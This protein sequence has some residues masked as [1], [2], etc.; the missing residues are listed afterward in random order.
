M[1]YITGRKQPCSYTQKGS[2]RCLGA[3]RLGSAAWGRWALAPGAHLSLRGTAVRVLGKPR[4]SQPASQPGLLQS[5]LMFTCVCVRTPG[6]GIA[7]P[8]FQGCGC[9][10]LGFVPCRC[11]FPAW[12]EI[13]V[14]QFNRATLVF[15]FMRGDKF[16]TCHLNNIP[17][18]ASPALPTDKS[19]PAQT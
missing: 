16:C 6:P 12:R 4:C 8:L 17:S 15:E 13:H 1:A 5:V 18:S 19:K 2:S 9:W 14:S 3:G 7:R 11:L 10:G